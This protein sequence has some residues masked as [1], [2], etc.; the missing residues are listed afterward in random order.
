MN[1][2]ILGGNL[3]AD[4]EVTETK[5]GKQVAKFR[6]ATRAFGKD[7]ESD[8]HNVVLWEPKGVVTYLTRG[9]KV[10]VRGRLQHRSYE[11]DGVMKYFSEVVASELELFGSRDDSTPSQRPAARPTQTPNTPNTCLL[12]T[13]PS[14]RDRTRSRMPSSA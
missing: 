6:M 7:S 12:Y 8:W 5:S 11:K 3:G 1:S 10:I 9:A 13:S 2:I 14:P 4:A